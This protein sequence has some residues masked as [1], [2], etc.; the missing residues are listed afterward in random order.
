[1]KTVFA[2]MMGFSLSAFAAG[3]VQGLAL[4]LT[5]LKSAIQKLNDVACET[6]ANC[7]SVALGH[8]ACGGP[9]S[10][11]VVSNLNPELA[12]IETLAT[13]T[14]SVEAQLTAGTF[15]VCSIV[16]PSPTACKQNR[17]VESL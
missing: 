15:G 7:G 14:A 10:Y 13:E 12:A 5:S 9:S 3:D 11:V 6:D 4:K 1:M 2:L 8:R 17:C 16:L